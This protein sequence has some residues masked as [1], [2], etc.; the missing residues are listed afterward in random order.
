MVRV[1]AKLFVVG[2]IGNWGQ[3][4]S[5]HK[6]Q[7]GAEEWLVNFAALREPEIKKAPLSQRFSLTEKY[8]ADNEEGESWFIEE[9][10]LAP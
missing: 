9:C 3:E 10:L 4:I 1:G 8:F 2:V 7:D 5:V 6:T